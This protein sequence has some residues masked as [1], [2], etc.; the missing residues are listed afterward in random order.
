[1]GL[2]QWG[3]RL[4][5]RLCPRAGRGANACP[6]ACAAPPLRAA[7][8]RA[9]AA[10]RRPPPACSAA[11]AQ[12]LHACHCTGAPLPGLPAAAQAGCRRPHLL[13]RSMPKNFDAHRRRR[14]PAGCDP[15]SRR[16]RSAAA[17]PSVPGLPG[18]VRQLYALCMQAGRADGPAQSGQG[19]RM[20]RDCGRT[21]Q[22][23]RQQ[24]PETAWR[25]QAPGGCLEPAHRSGT[26]WV[27]ASLRVGS[28]PGKQEARRGSHGLPL[29]AA[30]PV[31]PGGKTQPPAAPRR[32]ATAQVSSQCSVRAASGPHRCAS[33]APLMHCA[34][35]RV[36][37]RG[38]RPPP[39][40]LR[41]RH[42]RPARN[43]DACEPGPCKST[44]DGRWGWPPDA[45][46]WWQRGRGLVPQ[47]SFLRTSSASPHR[48][49]ITCAPGLCHA[50]R[51]PVTRPGALNTALE[52]GSCR[53][54]P[55]L[56]PR[57]GRPPNGGG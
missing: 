2:I 57:P 17:T 49:E 32:L 16:L 48:R 12:A 14:V 10:S 8:R 54:S 11:A 51:H 18:S 29:H 30:V 6:F 34:R 37:G 5:R 46:A 27:G 33:S 26:L 45:L 39:R 24:V 23:G 9:S 40:P 43:D 35:A 22:S 4:D 42:R 28:G 53:G 52:A 38:R 44:A 13:R 21:C 31:L 50:P 55:R 7:L 3:A 56:A 25:M 20:G 19:R 47:P 41:R 1:M 36:P 15:Y